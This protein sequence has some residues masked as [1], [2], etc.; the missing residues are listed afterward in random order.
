M[1]GWLWWYSYVVVE[2]A[3]VGMMMMMM[4]GGCFHGGVGAFTREGDGG[5]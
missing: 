2:V 5:A 4:Y 1:W 3:R